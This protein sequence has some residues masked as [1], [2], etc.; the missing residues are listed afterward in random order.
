MLLFVSPVLYLLIGIQILG[1]FASILAI[2]SALEELLIIVCSSRL[3]KDIRNF[4]GIIR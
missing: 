4:K 3:D 1:V 2:F